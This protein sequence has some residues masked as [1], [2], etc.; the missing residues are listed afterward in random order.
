[1]S[2]SGAASGSQRSASSTYGL[3][4]SAVEAS[5]RVPPIRSAGRWAVPGG[6]GHDERAAPA[7]GALDPHRPAMEL[8]QFLDQ[9]QAD[10]RALVGPAPRAFDA[11]EA[12]EEVGEFRRRDAGP[13]IADDQ[14]HGLPCRAQGDRDLAGE[15][16]LEGVGQE[17]EDDLLPHVPVDVDGLGQR[18]AV[19]DEP[20]PGPLAG[21]A[22]VAGEVGGHRGQVGGLVHRLHAARLDAREVEQR[23]HEL[24]EPQAVAMHDGEQLAVRRHDLV[25]GRGEDILDRSEHQ[26]QRRA[27]LVAHVAEEGGL[28]AIELGQDLGAVALLLVRARVRD[29][30]RD[31]RGGQVEEVAVVAG[32]AEEPTH[33]GDQ[34]AHDLCARRDR[35]HQHALGGSSPAPG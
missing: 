19:H 24:L 29:R 15:G 1:M 25:R 14:F 9:R 4:P 22:E 28:G 17:V 27:E 7:E 3:A 8:D 31:A 6:D 20:Q 26:R 12:L 30:R 18:R 34:R 16:E 35:Q 32:Q 11:V 33:A 23:V 5:V 2:G 21:R 10:A 13:G